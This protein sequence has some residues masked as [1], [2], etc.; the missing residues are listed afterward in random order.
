MPLAEL[1]KG[2]KD[3]EIYA[4]VAERIEARKVIK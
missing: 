2:L 1:T 4:T 3:T